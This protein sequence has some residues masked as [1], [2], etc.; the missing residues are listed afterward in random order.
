MRRVS[1]AD[2]AETIGR[3]CSDAAH[4]LPPAAR[5]RIGTQQRQCQRVS[6]RTQPY[7]FLTAGDG[8]RRCRCAL[9]DERQR[10][11]PE[12]FRQ[13]PGRLRNIDRPALDMCRA[14]EMDDDRMV[15]RTPF[16]GKD[17]GD[18]FRIGGIRP[19]PINGFGREG[20]QFTRLQQADGR[21][22]GSARGVIK[23]SGHGVTGLRVSG[24]IW[25]CLR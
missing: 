18:G 21:V 20:D 24:G 1:R 15:G 19:Q 4:A 13:I 8:K 16:G 25:E 3:W 6:R 5:L 17:F 10:P 22:K 12:G 11:R 23:D 14:R 2:A 9:E 7:R